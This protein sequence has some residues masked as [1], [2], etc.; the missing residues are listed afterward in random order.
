VEV[1]QHRKGP[2]AVGAVE[3]RRH[4]TV[5]AGD[6]HLLDRCDSGRIRAPQPATGHRGRELPSLRRRHRL[7]RRHAPPGG[8]AGPL[9][10]L[11]G[12]RHCAVHPRSTVTIAP[13]MYEASSLARNATTD[14]TSSGRARLPRG[15]SASTALSS[16]LTGAV[17]GG[18]SRRAGGATSVGAVRAE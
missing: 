6:H 14:A 10:D 12:D 9:L 16:M 13:V 7:E 18:D 8:P 15:M 17:A 11:D 3:T 5:A 4:R 1:E 2:G